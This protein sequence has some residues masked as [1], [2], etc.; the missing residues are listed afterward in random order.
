MTY[1]PVPEPPKRKIPLWVWIVA[2]VGVIFLM[3][4]SGMMGAVLVSTKS[5]AATIPT[6]VA[7]SEVEPVPSPTV[8]P[9]TTEP[10]VEA[11]ADLCAPYLADAGDYALSDQMSGQPTIE[12]VGTPETAFYAINATWV[13]PGLT[14][15]FD[16]RV[17]Q[18]NL[19]YAQYSTQDRRIDLVTGNT[20]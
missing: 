13:R 14:A 10:T 6:T 4:C 11:V 12:K 15:Q 7:P 5:P 17:W 8:S 9:T 16:C 18:G 3:C 1:Q 2:P 19:Q 20:L